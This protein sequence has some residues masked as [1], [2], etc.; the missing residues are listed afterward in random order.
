[1]LPPPYFYYSRDLSD[2]DCRQVQAE[3]PW[4]QQL[5]HDLDRNDGFD[6]SQH[7][8]LWLAQP[9]VTTHTHY[10][11]L[12][13]FYM[14]LKGAKQ[15]FLA[16]PSARKRLKVFPHTHQQTRQSQLNF[17]YH[18]DFEVRARVCVCVCFW[19]VELLH[20]QSNLV[21]VRSRQ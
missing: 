19:K 4:M 21:S 11:V 2:A 1:M 17:S 10:D 7:T 9:G 18:G 13:N 5:H 20:S 12:D 6:I 15:F 16:P 8:Q 14:Q 3:L